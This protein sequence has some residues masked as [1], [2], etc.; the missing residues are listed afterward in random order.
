M[1][2]DR[3]AARGYSGTTLPGGG[4]LQAV[5]ERF[6]PDAERNRTPKFAHRAMSASKLV[7]SGTLSSPGS[8]VLPPHRP[9]P[10]GHPRAP[11][12]YRFK[13]CL[14]SNL[15]APSTRT[16]KSALIQHSPRFTT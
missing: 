14:D 11:G 16:R 6:F 1:R 8:T 12:R 10:G 5:L 15:M 4:A 3:A 2:P 13:S 9:W 7:P